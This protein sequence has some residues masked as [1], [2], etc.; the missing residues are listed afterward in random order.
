MDLKRG[1]VRRIDR[2]VPLMP[3]SIILAAEALAVTL[4]IFVLVLGL[5]IRIGA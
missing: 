5:M 3:S 1:L 2:A 4:L